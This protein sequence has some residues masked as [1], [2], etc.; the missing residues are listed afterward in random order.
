[1]IKIG[2]RIFSYI[3][4]NYYFLYN[5]IKF[6]I[7]GV[8]ILDNTKVNGK[9]YI[10]NQGKISLGKNVYINS[11]ISSNMLGSSS[12][13]SLVSGFNGELYIGNNVGISNSSIT[14]HQRVVIKD[15]VT[16]GNGCKIIDT[17]FHPIGADDRLKNKTEKILMAEI[18]INENVFIGTGTIILKGVNIGQNSVIGAHSVVTRSIPSNEIWAGNPAKRIK[19]LTTIKELS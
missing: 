16:I 5:K 6:R 11:S 9:F 19:S 4:K 13:S 3:E 8:S 12:F 7:H 15:N 14:S 18:I 1:M 17:D 10:N 2:L